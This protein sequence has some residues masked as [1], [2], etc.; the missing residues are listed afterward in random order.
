MNRK[1]A[2]EIIERA[3]IS[4]VEES[5]SSKDFKSDRN[6]LDKAWR[7]LKESV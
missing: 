3:L 4:Y 2:E 1:R 5:L 6:E 7:Y